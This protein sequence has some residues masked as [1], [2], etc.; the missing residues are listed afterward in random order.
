MDVSMRYLKAER[1]LRKAHTRYAIALSLPTTGH[2]CCGPPVGPGVTEA[3]SALCT[4]A[5][6]RNSARASLPTDEVPR[7]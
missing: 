2:P 3:W 1:A 6:E 4:A 7:G 5:A